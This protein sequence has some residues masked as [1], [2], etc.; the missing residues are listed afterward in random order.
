MASGGARPNEE[1]YKFD[2]ELPDG[3]IARCWQALEQP[4]ADCSFSAGLVSELPPE[5]IY[6]CIAR[7]DKEPTMILLR[8]DEALALQWVL[9]GALWSESMLE[10][11][12]A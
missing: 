1:G 3:R 4:Y 7:D 11:E 9:S 8:R 12:D 2:Y 10:E 6:V 5:D